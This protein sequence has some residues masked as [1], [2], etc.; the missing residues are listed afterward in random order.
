[1]R[2]LTRNCD[3]RRD[4][5]GNQDEQRKHEHAHEGKCRVQLFLPGLCVK[6]VRDAL[7]ELLVERT[8]ALVKYQ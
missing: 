7:T 1:M 6:P 5:R 2:L 3:D 8:D 4:V